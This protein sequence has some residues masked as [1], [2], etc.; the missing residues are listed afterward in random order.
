MNCPKCQ[1]ACTFI[2]DRGFADGSGVVWLCPNLRC[3]PYQLYTY[4]DPEAALQERGDWFTD[5]MLRFFTWLS[6]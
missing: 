4:A 1:Q 2:R 6:R 5:L 3:N